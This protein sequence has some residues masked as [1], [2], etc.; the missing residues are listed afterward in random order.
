MLGRARSRSWPE[1]RCG[2]RKSRQ[3]AAIEESLILAS[4]AAASPYTRLGVGEIR[5]LE[6]YPGVDNEPLRANLRVVPLAALPY[7]AISYCWG[8]PIRTKQ[9]I[10]N[11]HS[12]DITENLFAVLR[13]HRDRTDIRFLWVD[14]ICIN[15]DNEDDKAC[16]LSIMASIYRQAGFV[17][18]YLD[19]H[20]PGY[21]LTSWMICWLSEHESKHKVNPASYQLG[22]IALLED[23]HQNMVYYGDDFHCPCCEE[24]FSWKLDSDLGRFEE[25]LRAMKDLFDLTWFQRLWTL[26]ENAVAQLSIFRFGQHWTNWQLLASAIK[27]SERYAYC[28]SPFNLNERAIFARAVR[29]ENVV[30]QY[31]ESVKAYNARQDTQCLLGIMISTWTLKS[32][33][34]KDR[35]NS[36]K[37]LAFVEYEADLQ[38]DMNLPVWAFWTR[39]ACFLLTR[40]TAWR[41]RSIYGPYICRSF[42]LTLAGLQHDQRDPL[43]PSWV[44]DMARLDR[45]SEKKYTYALGNQ[46]FN[47]AGG[48]HKSFN[49]DIET[50]PG[51]LFVLGV[52]LSEIVETLPGTQYRPSKDT[53]ATDIIRT[54]C[55]YGVISNPNHDEVATYRENEHGAA[56]VAQFIVELREWLLPW[57]IL[58]YVFAHNRSN[59]FTNG[60]YGANDFS[61]LITQGCVQNRPE[62]RELFDDDRRRDIVVRI[63][64]KPLEQLLQECSG[65]SQPKLSPEKF[66]EDMNIWAFPRVRGEGPCL[67]H[68]RILAHFSDGRVGWVPEHAQ[69]SD[70]V[71]LLKGAPEPYILRQDKDR[72]HSPIG[73]PLYSLVGDAYILGVM[74][75]EAWP[76]DFKVTDDNV[77][78]LI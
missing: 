44:P 17:D 74:G 7:C 56:W 78:G 77:I 69:K 61:S 54:G 48:R 73:A 10:V 49:V 25:G 15:Q 19:G 14:A 47:S 72:L 6:L 60:E 53:W 23:F 9:L 62:I 70:V 8:S 52:H 55:D 68:A 29:I 18:I 37:A 71:Y 75:G 64:S 16:Q 21:A 32:S 38:F 4:L 59:K 58:C 28:E 43:L 39:V 1:T 24:P 65:S 41:N 46:R 3:V 11:Q 31:T 27:I 42:V 20:R 63:V 22:P 12:I 51:T 76:S 2:T 45:Q 50:E 34:A 26:Q 33:F 67:D 35:L 5:V 66:Y 13:K 40:K 57:Y 30:A 36:I